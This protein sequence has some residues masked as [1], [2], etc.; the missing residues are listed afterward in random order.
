MKKELILKL[1]IFSLFVSI[2]GWY[3]MTYLVAVFNPFLFFAIPAFLT[4]YQIGVISLIHLYLN[5]DSDQCSRFLLGTKVFKVLLSIAFVLITYK[6]IGLN[7]PFLIT[8]LLYYM[9]FI[10]FDSWV[11][12]RCNKEHKRKIEKYE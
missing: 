8:F 3:V 6:V 7:T 11:F 4:L 5:G 9:V 1:V 10:F 2:G 12:I